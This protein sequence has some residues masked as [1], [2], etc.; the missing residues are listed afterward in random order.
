M[1]GGDKVSA[2]E[3]ERHVSAH[4]KVEQAAVIPVADPVLGERVCACVIPAA[5]GAPSLKEL[6]L[7]LSSRGM[8]DFKLPE[9]LVLR[10]SFPLT[11]LGKVDKKRLR[12]DVA[13]PRG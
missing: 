10:E 5:D 9:R 6:K 3:V 11:G 7:F 8:A 4:P 2:T 13:G 12:A 1:R